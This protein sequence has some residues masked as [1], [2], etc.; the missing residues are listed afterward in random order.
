MS[1]PQKL[2]H[3]NVYD[4]NLVLPT[5]KQVNKYFFHSKALVKWLINT[6]L[7]LVNSTLHDD[8]TDRIV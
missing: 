2:G 7:H 4:E 3:A 6:N 5:S 1:N 8:T